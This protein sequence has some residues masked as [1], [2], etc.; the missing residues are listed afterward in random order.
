MSDSTF[1]FELVT[2]E[3]VLVSKEVKSVSIP[4][5]EG[6]MTVL[7]DHSAV[8]T[9]LRPGAIVVNSEG[10]ESEFLVSGGFVEITQREVVVLAEKAVPREK[11]S[12]D[13]FDQIIEKT[14]R[15]LEHASDLQI[16]L[17][18]K[19]LN[20]LVEIKEKLQK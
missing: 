5:A 9:V 12:P 11:A 10:Q 18:T 8:A 3:I 6:D 1:N 20:D 13:I 15:N 2:P 7:S 16:S 17:L 14:K 19:K 4:G